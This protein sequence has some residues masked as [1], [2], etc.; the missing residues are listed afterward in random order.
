MSA[1]FSWIQQVCKQQLSKELSCSFLAKAREREHS[2]PQLSL[3]RKEGLPEKALAPYLIGQKGSHPL[4]EPT[5]GK[6][7]KTTLTPIGHSLWAEGKPPNS[8]CYLRR[9]SG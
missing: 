4:S 8:G 7:E 1:S 3:E 5:I 9:E 6:D 2:F